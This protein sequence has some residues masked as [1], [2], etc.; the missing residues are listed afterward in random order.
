[1]FGPNLAALAQ[2]RQVIAA[3]LQAHG[4]TADIDRPITYEAM[5]DDVAALIRY[6]GFKT[7]DVMGYSLGG[8]VATQVAIRHPDLVRKLVVVSSAFRQDGWYP[9]I[10]AGMAQ[11]SPAAAEPMKQTPM[12][13]AYARLAP[14]PQ[15]WPVLLTKLGDLLRKDY[16]WSRDVA[17]IQAPTLIVAGDADAVRT[18]HVVQFF[19]LLGGGKRDAGWDGSGRPKGR[20]A[21]LAGASHYDIFAS[22]ALAAVVNPFLD[23]P[24]PQAR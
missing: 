12:Y 5:A 4:R 7:A 1:M 19:E 23:A 22:P 15:D 20:L 2:G 6:L 8:G 24:M 14:R 11:M 21:I 17:S 3:E 13:E 16:D 9:E 18:A 10:L